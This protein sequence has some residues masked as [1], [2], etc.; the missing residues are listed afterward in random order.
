MRYHPEHVDP[1]AGHLQHEQHV[2]P[3]QEDGVH[4]E[5]IHRRH[6]VDL[7]AEELPPGQ[8][9]PLGCRFDTGRWRMVQMVLA[10]ILPL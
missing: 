1:V 10:A 7:G 8:R 6:T 9:R 3:L 2:Q 4:G 5:E